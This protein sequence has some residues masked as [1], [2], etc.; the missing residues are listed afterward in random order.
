VRRVLGI[1]DPWKRFRDFE[2]S[3]HPDT[4][5]GQAA[6]LQWLDRVAPTPDGGDLPQLD[7]AS[8]DPV[9]RQFAHCWARLERAFRGKHA[10]LAATQRVLIDLP[11]FQ[12]TPAGHSLLRNLGS[13]LEFCGTPVHY[14]REPTRFA[15]CL[16]G[17]R[18]TVLVSLDH[19]WWYDPASALRR[20]VV[21][22]VRDYQ[23]T[24]RLVLGL[25]SNHF[26][27][28]P[29][30]LRRRLDE[31]RAVGVQFF[32]SFQAEPFVRSRYRPYTD[33]GFRVCSLEFGANPLVFHPVPGVERDLNFVYLA[34]SNY[35]KLDRTVAYL[36]EVFRDYPGV[37]LGPGWPRAAADQLPD[38]QLRYLYARARVG[39]NLHVPFQVRSASELNE[40]AYNL[41]SCGAPQLLDNPALLPQR[42]GPASV[43]SAATPEE[44]GRLFRHILAHP[45]E[46]AGRAVNALGEVLG[47]HTV[48]HRVD[49]LVDVLR[50][51]T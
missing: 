48:F 28:D 29:K 1:P 20:N 43:Y 34:S 33:R 22:A 41:A 8:A 38:H 18:P 23:R 25:T 31:A 32:I 3:I 2:R 4:W 13:A 21:E 39:V 45:D 11:S 51:L 40:R 36:R 19:N 46:A 17:F 10:G 37:L 44:Y 50:G 24:G 26:P 12:L 42:L 27:T 35:E 49:Q 6:V 30:V 5:A 14:W 15:A 47:R 16:D 7:P 9:V